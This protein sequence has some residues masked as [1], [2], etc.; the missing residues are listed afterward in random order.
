MKRIDTSNN[1]GNMLDK[2]EVKITIIKRTSL[3]DVIVKEYADA[4]YRVI[5][6]P[7]EG[8]GRY[9]IIRERPP[10]KVSNFLWWDTFH[11]SKPLYIADFKVVDPSKK[12]NSIFYVARKIAEESGLPELYE[13]YKKLLGNPLFMSLKVYG[14]K[15]LD[16]GLLLPTK[17]IAEE[18]GVDRV[19]IELADKR[20]YVLLS[21][22]GTML[23][24][25][26]E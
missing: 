21:D 22:G 17:K 13:L 20:P 12:P 9:G 8:E 25:D 11:R 18:I 23:L 24:E 15:N 1:E 7:D 2:K 16:D 4:G 6:R 10:K 26:S 3:V 14:E 5:N 19:V